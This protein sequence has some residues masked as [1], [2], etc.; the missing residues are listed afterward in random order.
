[1]NNFVI[2]TPD[3]FWQIRWLD[4]YM[5]GHKGFIAGGC[6]KNIL[7]GERVKDIDIFFESESDFQEAVDLFNDEKHQKEGWKFKYRNKKVCAF[8]KEGEKVWIEFIESEFGKPKEIL[9]SFDF[10]VTKMAYY[11]EPK[12]EEKEDDYF[13]FSSA[14][15]V[16]YEYK[17]LYHEKF[18]EYLHMKR[19]VIDENIPFPVSTWERS[20]RYK[21]YGY[22][23]CRE[24]KKKLLQALKGVNVS[25]KNERCVCENRVP[26]RKDGLYLIYGNGHAEP[27]TGDNSKDCVQYIGLK[28]RYMSFAISLTEHDIVQLLDDD[29]REES[30]SGTYYEREC[31]ALFDIDGRGNTERLVARNP[32][33]R[34]LLEDGEY[35]PSLGQLNLMAHYMDELNKAFAY[36]SASPLSSTWYWS[37]TESSQAVAWY[38]VF[39]SGLTGTG[40]KHIGDMVRTVI[41]F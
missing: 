21:G 20:Y 35:I 15:I 28:H 27:F 6:F 18:F 2:D 38:V 37:S 16:A 19:L 8:Q 33:L 25:P 29:S 14:S 39:S 22:N 7:S 26:S 36:V 13:P 17:L 30:G 3:N 9:R 5:E 40:N 10:T 12:Y 1:M 41:D 32:K 34:N 23:M 4:K 31:D 11:K 24:T